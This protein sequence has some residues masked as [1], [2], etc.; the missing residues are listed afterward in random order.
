[1]KLKIESVPVAQTIEHT[2]NN[3]KVMS[4]VPNKYMYL[5]DV[6]LKCSESNIE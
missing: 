6:K 1:M 3:T 4:T 2:D 5:Q